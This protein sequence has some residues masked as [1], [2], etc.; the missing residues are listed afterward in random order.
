MQ[1]HGDFTWT[2]RATLARAAQDEYPWRHYLQTAVEFHADG[3]AGTVWP[4]DAH[5]PGGDRPPLGSLHVITA[6]QPDT[7]PA[8][9]DNA[10]RMTVLDHELQAADIASLRASG[11]SFDGKHREESRAV[12]GLDDERARALGLRLG[13]VAIFSWRGRRWSLLA[14]AT[15]RQDHRGW[16]WQAR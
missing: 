10:A 2:P 8:S 5:L 4:L 9:A 1:E 3:R 6:I 11:V 7:D 13:Q 15:D 16:R 14:C 12:F